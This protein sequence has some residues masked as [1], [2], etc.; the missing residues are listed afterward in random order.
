MRLS[1]ELHHRMRRACTAASNPC[2]SF[3]I[4]SSLAEQPARIACHDACVPYL[5]PSPHGMRRC[6]LA[7]VQ[8]A[9]FRLQGYPAPKGLCWAI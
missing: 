3:P 4:K 7:D 5:A 6:R 1:A 2:V 9:H 8:G